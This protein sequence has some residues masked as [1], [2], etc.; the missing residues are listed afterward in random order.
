MLFNEVSLPGA[1]LI[2]PEFRRDERGAYA[3]MFCR[4]EFSAH[5]LDP[6]VVQCN[7]S[8]NRRQ[9]TLRGIH[10]Q[11]EPHAEVKLVRAQRGAIYDVIVDLRKDSPTFAKWYGVT[12]T[13]EN[14]L[15]LYVP[16]GFGH[17]FLTLEDDTEVHYQVS[18]SYAPHVSREIRWN[19]PQ[20]GI[21]WPIQPTIIS[22]KDRNAALLADTMPWLSTYGFSRE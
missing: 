9:G 4:E 17:S 21:A 13:A 1:W 15:A 11:S 19:D 6:T 10:F 3:R 12:L 20:I 7:L 22:D 5:G 14:E 2:E 16:K 18:N 8:L